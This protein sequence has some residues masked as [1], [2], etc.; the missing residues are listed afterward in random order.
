VAAVSGS[1]TRHD[2]HQNTN[3]V[4]LNVTRRQGVQVYRGA[5][6]WVKACRGTKSLEA[7]PRK[8]LAGKAQHPYLVLRIVANQK[9]A[10]AKGF[11]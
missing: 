11:A 9:T 8:F 2:C 4:A 1:A 10:V 3:G 7:A 6:A 5:G